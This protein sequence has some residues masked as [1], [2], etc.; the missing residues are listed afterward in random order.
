MMASKGSF[1]WGLRLVLINNYFT[2]EI[3]KGIKIGI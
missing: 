3:K 2:D 1:E